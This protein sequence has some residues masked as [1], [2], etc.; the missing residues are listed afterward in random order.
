[1]KRRGVGVGSTGNKWISWQKICCTVKPICLWVQCMFGRE[2][3]NLNSAG[4]PW[5]GMKMTAV[6]GPPGLLSFFHLIT[7]FSRLSYL[8]FSLQSKTNNEYRKGSLLLTLSKYARIHVISSCY[9]SLDPNGLHYTR[10]N[11]F[12]QTFFKL[13]LH[14]HWFDLRW[15]FGKPI[16]EHFPWHKDGIKFVWQLF[17]WHRSKIARWNSFSW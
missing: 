17:L 14:K 16:D 10:H 2:F 5:K 12:A 4:R 1:M 15:W 6:R 7:Y 3:S 11:S 13:E 8:F 9:G